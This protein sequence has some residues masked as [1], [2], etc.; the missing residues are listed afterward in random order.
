MSYSNDYFPP[1]KKVV[2][3][4]KVVVWSVG[5]N[6]KGS[7]ETLV[8]FWAFLGPDEGEGREPGPFT[9]VPGTQCQQ[10]EAASSRPDADQELAFMKHLPSAGPFMDQLT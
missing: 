8:L 7:Q 6:S 2:D 5:Y 4:K 1:Q 10:E 3:R 9:G